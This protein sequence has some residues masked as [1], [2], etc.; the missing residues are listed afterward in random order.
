M[1]DV[2][3]L[4]ERMHVRVQKVESISMEKP[5]AN[6]H[7]LQ[8]NNNTP[9]RQQNQL[10]PGQGG[11]PNGQ[12]PQRGM[13]SI[14]RWLL[15]IVALMLGIYLYQYFSA[16]N[17]SSSS[18]R[19]ELKYSEFYQQINAENIK[20][21]TIIGQTDIQ[22][23]FC[24]PVGGNTQY[25]VEQLPN[26][27][28]NLTPDLLKEKPTCAASVTVITQAPSDNSFWLNLLIS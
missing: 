8:N 14:N 18:Q 28:P 21:A 7:W 16:S 26:G 6:M 22:G 2:Y 20:T 23:E 12:P 15:I 17:N 3:L 11:R 5:P 27:D 13:S 25:H 24:S 19:T 4:V 9:Q 10:R 1:A